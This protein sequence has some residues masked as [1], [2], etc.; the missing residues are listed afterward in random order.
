MNGVAKK[1]VAG[2][3]P[4]QR[5]QLVR[6]RRQI[7]KLVGARFTGRVMVTMHLGDCKVIETQQASACDEVA[8]F[9]TVDACMA[10]VAACQRD[11]LCGDISF[12]MLRGEVSEPMQRSVM[13]IRL[14]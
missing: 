4:T 8:H 10:T 14:L 6:V 13:P 3:E 5:D 7:E 1:D 2:A 12:S 9:V 11:Q